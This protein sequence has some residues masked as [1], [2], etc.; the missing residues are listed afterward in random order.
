MMSNSH[1]FYSDDHVRAI[2]ENARV[3]AMVGASSNVVRPSYGVMKFLQ[4]RGRRVYPVNPQIVGQEILGEKVFAEIG[5][6]PE[7]IDMVDIF[8]KSEAVGPIVDQAI[9]LNVPVV[10]MQLGV[11]NDVVAARAEAMGVRVIMNRCPAIE[12]ERLS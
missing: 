3:I 2:L 10:W 5:E 1:D 11:R 9:A 12:F 8:R 7:K 4:A 6:I